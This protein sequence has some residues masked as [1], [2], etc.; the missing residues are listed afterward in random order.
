MQL[1]CPELGTKDRV[2]VQYVIK[3]LSS[4][5]PGAAFLQG[6]GPAYRGA[7]TIPSAH[8]PR[9]RHHPLVCRK[10]SLH[11]PCGRKAALPATLSHA[12]LIVTAPRLHTEPINMRDHP[13]PTCYCSG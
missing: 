10:I 12:L 7:C 4:S 13:K 9:R 2:V 5:S 8:A 1:S 11:P 6:T 3:D